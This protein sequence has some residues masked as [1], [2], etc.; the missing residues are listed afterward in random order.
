MRKPLLAIA[1]VLSSAPLQAEIPPALPEIE[2]PP[3][4]TGTSDDMEPE[5]TISRRGE[6]TIEEYRINGELYMVKVIPAKGVPYY[7]MDA[8]G[9]GSLETR[10][11]ELD[12]RLL[13]P[14]WSIFRW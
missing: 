3:V 10:R 11:G 5:V 9:D 2:P 1:L 8:D 14:S 12:P 4:P 7:L 13:V 6:E